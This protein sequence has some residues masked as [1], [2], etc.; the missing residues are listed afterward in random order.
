MT[1]PLGG[2]DSD[3]S[4]EVNIDIDWPK[5]G[6]EESEFPK[7]HFNFV[8]LPDPLDSPPES[9][10][11]SPKETTSRNNAILSYLKNVRQKPTSI[12]RPPQGRVT[13]LQKRKESGKV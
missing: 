2:F 9:K 5:R 12:L 8:G 4:I 10:L 13:K 6:L 3:E 11:T 1:V 7:D